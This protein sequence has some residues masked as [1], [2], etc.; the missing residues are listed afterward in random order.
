MRPPGP[1]HHQANIPAGGDAGS[2][3]LRR[4]GTTRQHC[5]TGDGDRIS[6]R[7]VAHQVL[8]RCD[9]PAHL[10]LEVLRFMTARAGELLTDQLRTVTV[11]RV[12]FGR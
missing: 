5:A 3:A 9:H 8:E 11:C 10:A 12:A 2:P 1:E 6:D 7:R 4:S